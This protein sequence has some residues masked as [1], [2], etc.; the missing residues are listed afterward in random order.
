MRSTWLAT[1]L[2]GVTDDM[3]EAKIANREL[4]RVFQEVGRLFGVDKYVVNTLLECL[5]DQEPLADPHMSRSLPCPMPK[6]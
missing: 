6:A 2:K 5:P 4:L 3:A 1:P